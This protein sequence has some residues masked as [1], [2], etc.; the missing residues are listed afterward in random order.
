MPWQI[1]SKDER[2]QLHL[3][4]IVEGEQYVSMDI[5]V[6]E[7]IPQLEEISYCPTSATQPDR[8][9]KFIF[10]YFSNW[11]GCKSC[12][13]FLEKWKMLH[14]YYVSHIFAELESHYSPL[15]NIFITWSFHRENWKHIFKRTQSLFQQIFHWDKSLTS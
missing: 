12:T 2:M 6:L 4:S 14:V 15:E 5:L 3:L 13:S 1:L 10:L 11:E 7:N 8:G 9:W